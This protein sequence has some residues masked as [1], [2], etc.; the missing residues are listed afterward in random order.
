MLRAAAQTI[1]EVVIGQDLGM[2]DSTSSDTAEIFKIINKT[3]HLSQDLARK[4][5]FVLLL[6]RPTR[7]T[8][9]IIY[10][11]CRVNG[12]ARSRTPRHARSSR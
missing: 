3:L 6:L 7:L 4:V 12:T 8:I 1:G 2:L 5:R 9:I 11:Y 10:L